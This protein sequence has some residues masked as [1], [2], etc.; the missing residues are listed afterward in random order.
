[1]AIS[2]EKCVQFAVKEEFSKTGKS[3]GFAVKGR[4]EIHHPLDI[5]KEKG[6]RLVYDSRDEADQKVH[7]LRAA[8]ETDG[9]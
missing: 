3:E 9:A 4:A 6:L 7:A 2:V 8:Q 5:V 1:M